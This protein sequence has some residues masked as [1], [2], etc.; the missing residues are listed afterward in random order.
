MT[1]TTK[2]RGP[3][4][5]EQEETP[6]SKSCYH[7]RR[8]SQA[9]THCDWLSATIGRSQ[10]PPTLLLEEGTALELMFI[11]GQLKLSVAATALLHVL[12]GP[13]RDRPYGPPL[14]S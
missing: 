11:R 8:G 5:E 1:F 4:A 13:P 6:L 3:G 2:V 12:L 7:L 14:R 9:S 10:P